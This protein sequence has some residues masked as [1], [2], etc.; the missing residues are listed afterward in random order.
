MKNGTS[1]FIDGPW[2]SGKSFLVWAWVLK[3][4]RELK[5]FV[6]RES[7]EGF[8]K[9]RGTAWR[10]SPRFCQIAEERKEFLAY[11]LDEETYA[12]L[13][14]KKEQFEAAFLRRDKRKRHLAPSRWDHPAVDFICVSGDRL[15]GRCS[16]SSAEM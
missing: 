10:L 4:T 16:A 1:M 12:R 11:D 6:V 14:R 15:M 13:S 5:D 2:G 3:T 7:R 8:E 9:S